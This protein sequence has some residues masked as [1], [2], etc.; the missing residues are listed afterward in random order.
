VS[1]IFLVRVL[2]EQY[3][4]ASSDTSLL[5]YEEGFRSSYERGFLLIGVLPL[6]SVQS[7]LELCAYRSSLSM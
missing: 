4:A 5:A 3:M 2:W 6:T 1:R 7:W